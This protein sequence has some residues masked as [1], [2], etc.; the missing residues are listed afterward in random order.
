MSL[1][2]LIAEIPLAKNRA[3]AA[4]LTKRAKA[5]A[6]ELQFAL[7]NLVRW[8]D[9]LTPSDIRVAKAALARARGD[10]P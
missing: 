1:C 4:K 6:D 3:E 5:I 2:E 10:K 9:Q 7:G 8:H